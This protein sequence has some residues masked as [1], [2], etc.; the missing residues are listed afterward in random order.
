MKRRNVSILLALV[1]SMV[2]AFTGC[3]NKAAEP[4]ATDGGN[5]S[6]GSD[7]TIGL[8]VKTMGNPLFREIAYAAKQYADANGI[9]LVMV[10]TTKDGQLVEQLQQLDDLMAKGVDALIVTPQDT[11]G[12]TQG[13]EAAKAKGIPFIVIDTDAAGD[14]ED[15]YIGMDNIQGGYDLAKK[16]CEKM[17]G[18]GN[19]IVLQ[20]V[21]A[22]STSIQR[23][24]GFMKA[25]KE[26]P[27]IKVVASQNAD[28]E[29][30]KG[31]QVTADIL[32]ANKDIK[33]VVACN[34]LMAL[35]AIVS[36]EEAGYTCGGP[37]GVVVGSY[38]IST[39]VLEAVKE[40]KIYATGYHWGQLYGTWGM[41]MAVKAVKGEVIPA[42][43]TSPHSEI[44]LENVD[45]YMEWAKVIADYKFDAK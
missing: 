10:A 2:L 9:N 3:G 11:Q 17:G 33:G 39:P 8:Q 23:T 36:L 7:I 27:G 34:D 31:Q 16:V 32:Q 21:A 19:I 18:K 13:I 28:F 22:A 14:T 4:A 43:V 24:E 44:T 15:C 5:A 29:Q 26:Y 45:K 38:D 12:I 25:I 37:D 20:G 35:G 42:H 40:G 1:L 30:S 6:A 41:E